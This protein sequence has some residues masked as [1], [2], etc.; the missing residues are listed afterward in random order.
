MAKH[1]LI[2]EDEDNIR[3]M[4]GLTLEAAGYEVAEASDGAQG[5]K[6]YGDGSNYELVLLDQRMPGMDGLATLRQLKHRNAAARVV[7]V[8]AYASVELAVDAMKLG[9]TDFVRK[10]LTP[11]ILRGAVQ[12]ALVKD[13]AQTITTSPRSSAASEAAAILTITLN[14]FEIL[15]RAA[16]PS[17]AANELTFIVKSPDGDDNEVIVAITQNLV[18]YV[19]RVTRR[20]LPAGNSFWMTRAERFLGEYLW[21]VGRIPPGGR[22]TLNEIA[23]AELSVAAA[24]PE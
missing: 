2:I 18:A 15:R 7:M 9:A 14:G 1:I 13:E 21:S 8:T 10:P 23:Q 16:T 4:M 22:L 3:R 6:A 5:I 11:E 19:E 20:Q 17:S 24:W 12:A